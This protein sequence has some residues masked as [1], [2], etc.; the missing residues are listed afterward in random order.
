M[1]GDQARD[2][3]NEVKRLQSRWIGGHVDPEDMLILGKIVE[4]MLAHMAAALEARE[5]VPRRA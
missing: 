3:Q 5:K 4:E 1:T 2:L